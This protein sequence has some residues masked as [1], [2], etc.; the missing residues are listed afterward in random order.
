[1]CNFFSSYSKLEGYL[2]WCSIDRAQLSLSSI[3][4]YEY[5]KSKS[6]ANEMSAFNRTEYGQKKWFGFKPNEQRIIYL[7]W[8]LLI[9]FFSFLSGKPKND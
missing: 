1:M 2:K 5:R 7:Y 4:C 6:T 3:E 9:E 8:Y